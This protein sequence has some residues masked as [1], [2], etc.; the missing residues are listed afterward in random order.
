MHPNPPVSWGSW[1]TSSPPLHSRLH[2]RSQRLRQFNAILSLPVPP[3]PTL[4]VLECFVSDVPCGNSQTLRSRD[5]L[6][7]LRPPCFVY[8]VYSHSVSLLL[9][10]CTHNSVIVFN[11]AFFP[12]T[13]L[14]SRLE[15]ASPGSRHVVETP[16]IFVEGDGKRPWASVAPAGWG[17]NFGLER[18]RIWPPQ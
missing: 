10:S 5:E 15:A 1:A 7:T 6:Q 9:S 8:S 16:E 14:S 13:W 4:G 3:A 2:S 17:C 12:Y 18:K 11:I